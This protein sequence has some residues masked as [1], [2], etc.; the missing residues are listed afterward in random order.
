MFTFVV[1]IFHLSAPLPLTCLF[2]QSMTYVFL[3]S[4]PLLYN[5]HTPPTGLFTYAWPATTAGLPYL[6]LGSFYSLPFS[7]ALH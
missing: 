4:L 5:Q 1:Q 3:V 6:S 7:M 2:W